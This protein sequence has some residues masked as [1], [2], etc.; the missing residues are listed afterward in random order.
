LSVLVVSRRKIDGALMVKV[1]MSGSDATQWLRMR[2][3]KRME[4]GEEVDD[5]TRLSVEIG[6]RG[7]TAAGFVD[8][9]SLGELV[10]GDVDDEGCKAFAV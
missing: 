5:W 7:V 3:A 4:R 10:H 1:V 6:T 8:G 2:A 9:S